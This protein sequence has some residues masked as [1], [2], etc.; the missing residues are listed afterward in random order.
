[1]CQDIQDVG[2]SDTG[3]EYSAP[4]DA[5][6][7]PFS[8]SDGRIVRTLSFST[9]NDSGMTDDDM[10]RITTT[11]T[12]T[13]MIIHTFIRSTWDILCPPLDQNYVDKICI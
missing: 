9:G 7:M 5:W 1:M 13:E 12:T 11:I 4:I 3:L 10:L 6:I 2:M 8:G